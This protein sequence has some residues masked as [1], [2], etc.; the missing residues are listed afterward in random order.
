MAELTET[1]P[2]VQY[3]RGKI[4]SQV[5][6]NRMKYRDYETLLVA[7]GDADLPMPMPSRSQLRSRLSGC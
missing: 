2:L 6:I 4:S 7:L 1:H 5:A 3:S